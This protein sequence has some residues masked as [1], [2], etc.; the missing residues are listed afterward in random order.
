[1]SQFPTDPADLEQGAQ[2]G[3]YRR[4]VDRA[5]RLPGPT[6][7]LATPGLSV[8]PPTPNPAT[9]SLLA[10]LDRLGGLVTSVAV[11]ESQDR[12]R[13]SQR[14]A[15]DRER[16]ARQ[17][18][19]AERG[20]ATLDVDTMLP[21]LEDEILS[22]KA[23]LPENPEEFA[24]Q[25]VTSRTQGRSEAYAERFRQRLQPALVQAYTRRGA[26]LRERAAAE[27]LNDRTQAA[28]GAASADEL[29]SI[30]ATAKTV[31]GDRTDDEL[32]AS[33]FLP[34]LKNAAETG[35]QGRFDATMT[36]LG[37]GFIPQKTAA[38]EL[39]T[40]TLRQAEIEKARDIED[41]LFRRLESED[42]LA[43]EG[44]L[45]RLFNR[46][47]IGP[48]SSRRVRS[49]IEARKADI[50]RQ[51]EKLAVENAK[52]TADAEALT[53]A[54]TRASTREVGSGLFMLQD[55]TVE[56]PNGQTYTVK[57]K[58]VA[59]R[60][61]DQAMA[62]FAERFADD[63]Q[64]AIA[65]QVD[66]VA[67]NGVVPSAWSALLNNADLDASINSILPGPQREGQETAPLSVPPNLAAAFDLHQ[68]ISAINPRV[69]AR[70]VTNA[71]AAKL[72]ELAGAA[73]KLPQY[74]NDAGKAMV[75]AVRIASDDAWWQ[76]IGVPARPLAEAVD[77]LGGVNA[78]YVNRTIERN[79]K[80][81]LQLNGVSP[82]QALDQAVD[83]FKATHTKVNDAWVETAR[84]DVGDESFI[85]AAT[86]AAAARYL[87]EPGEDI[88]RDSLILVGNGSGDWTLYRSDIMQPVERLRRGQ[89]VFTTNDLRGIVT[90]MANQDQTGDRRGAAEAAARTQA[91]RPTTLRDIIRETQQTL[92]GIPTP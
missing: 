31:H 28:I 54:V 80:L 51:A 87:P 84:Q 4:S 66:F 57:A 39:L 42:P 35:D 68:R 6:E 90:K 59:Q 73:M 88:D 62:Q 56:L 79:A 89:S 65:A 9:Q 14:A 64:K 85:K 23:P 17:A 91:N 63:P 18:A 10:A 47:A 50:S 2:R 77:D 70:A 30:L 44:E 16:V 26:A 71:D 81:F 72:Y 41:H 1:M 38:K 76:T 52:L 34:A 24:A 43:V 55:R 60:V 75:A 22:G 21:R 15:V 74:G 69:A 78:G 83:S 8:L 40:R 45:N 7:T 92:E 58:D 61:T 5:V 53:E 32:K 82:E 25:F 19:D 29:A 37:D 46:G 27:D 33:L 13:A 48:D 36:A 49:V 67:R 3:V 86:K 20:Q 12:I 11:G